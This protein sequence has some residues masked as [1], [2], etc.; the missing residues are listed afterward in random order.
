[1]KSLAEG[2]PKE[3]PQ[4]STLY[5]FTLILTFRA[6]SSSRLW[7]QG[8]IQEENKVYRLIFEKPKGHDCSTPSDFFENPTHS[9][10]RI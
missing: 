9:L 1:M 7:S 4:A 5:P 8:K 2:Q 3:E 10:Q 6:R